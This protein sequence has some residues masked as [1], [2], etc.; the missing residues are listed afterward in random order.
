MGRRNVTGPHADGSA[1]QKPGRFGE[2]LAQSSVSA[3]SDVC[4]GHHFSKGSAVQCRNR[5]SMW[6]GEAGQGPRL[7]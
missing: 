6:V 4:G 1:G 3:M 2:A 7:L 5:V